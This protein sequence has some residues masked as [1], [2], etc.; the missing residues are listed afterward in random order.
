MENNL[1][2]K[3]QNKLPSGSHEKKPNIDTNWGT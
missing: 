2:I 1:P 3:F